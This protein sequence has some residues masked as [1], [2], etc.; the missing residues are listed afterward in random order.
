M[1]KYQV[2][3]IPPRQ[4]SHSGRLS[5]RSWLRSSDMLPTF[6]SSGLELTPEDQEQLVLDPQY[7][8]G[9]RTMDDYYQ[10]VLGMLPEVRQLFEA[11]SSSF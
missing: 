4:G 9:D 7:Q 2:S 8:D 1:S 11:L 5:P 6:N 10:R 3:I